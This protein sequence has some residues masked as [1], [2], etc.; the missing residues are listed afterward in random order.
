MA[1]L[2]AAASAAG[3]NDLAFALQS[4]LRMTGEM[5]TSEL[6]IQAYKYLRAARGEQEAFDWLQGAIPAEM[7]TGAAMMMYGEGEYHLL[8]ELMR[9]PEEGPFRTYAWMLRA[10]AALERPG[11][12]SATE[13]RRLEEHYARGLISRAFGRVQ[14]LVGAGDRYDVLGHYLMGRE[15]EGAV[16]ALPGDPGDRCEV[17]YYLGLKAR[18]EGRGEDAIGWWRVA[19]ETGQ[20][21]E[22]E[23]EWAW[24]RLRRWVEE[25]RRAR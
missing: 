17:A 10:A 7:R 4:R 14:R 6:P 11:D 18:A 16:L 25:G 15:S 20:A 22:G 24:S 8:W 21:Q 3:R 5:W 12:M 1:E 13:R 9:E 19:I 2:S 23:Y